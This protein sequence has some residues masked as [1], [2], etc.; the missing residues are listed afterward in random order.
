MTIQI[1]PEQ[2][3]RSA[4]SRIGVKFDGARVLEIGAG[5]GRVTKAFVSAAKSIVAIEPDRD[6]ASDFRNEAWPAH[7]E[8]HP[9]GIEKFDPAGRRFDV[10]LFSWS[11]C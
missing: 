7:V 9:V 11:L 6:A 5:D 1:D 2:N 8:F 3:E 10:I 4:L